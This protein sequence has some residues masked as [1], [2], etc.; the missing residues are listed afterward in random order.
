MPSTPRAFKIPSPGEVKDA[1]YFKGSPNSEEV[2][3]IERL[4]AELSEGYTIVHCVSRIKRR[5]KLLTLF[6]Q[7]VEISTNG[8]HGANYSGGCDS[9]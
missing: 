1:Q 8:G 4:I 5:V 6:A 3:L 9:D 7:V 2:R